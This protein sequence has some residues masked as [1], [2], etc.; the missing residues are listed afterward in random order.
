LLAGR[1][2]S[3]LQGLHCV[4]RLRLAFASTDGAGW[5]RDGIWTKKKQTYH[6]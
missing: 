4:K 1:A 3:G 6:W 5:E 2:H